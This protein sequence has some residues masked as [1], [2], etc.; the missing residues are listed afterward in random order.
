MNDTRWNSLK[1]GDVV[2]SATS[3]HCFVVTGLVVGQV[4]SGRR[5]IEATMTRTVVARSGSSWNIVTANDLKM[6][7]TL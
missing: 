7:E 4:A 5:G 6:K 2:K 1:L 3:S